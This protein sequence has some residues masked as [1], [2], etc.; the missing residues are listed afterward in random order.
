MKNK[1]K[2]EE[3]DRAVGNDLIT[4]DNIGNKFIHMFTGWEK[5]LKERITPKE[6]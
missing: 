6:D 1:K 5:I 4:T 3:K 2:K